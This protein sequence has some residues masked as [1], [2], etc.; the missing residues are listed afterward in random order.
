M[1][2]MIYLSKVTA[3]GH[4]VFTSNGLSVAP[5]LG[6][7][8][9]WMNHRSDGSLDSRSYHTGCPVLVGNKWIA[10][11]WVKWHGQMWRYPCSRERGLHY[12]PF[13]NRGKVF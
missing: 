2:W 13:D 6:S 8:L 7:V 11:K 10:N 5:D 9:M 1:T 4:T 12:R 3:G